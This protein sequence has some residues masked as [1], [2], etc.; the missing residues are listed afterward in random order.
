[1]SDTDDAGRISAQAAGLERFFR[2]ATLT[3]VNRV[4]VALIVV[5]GL[6]VALATAS[7]SRTHRGDAVEAAV[8]LS[9]G[10]ALLWIFLLVMRYLGI[11]RRLHD[12][13]A[14]EVARLSARP[15]R[16]Q[17]QFLAD[18]ELAGPRGRV[19]SMSEDPVATRG[20]PYGETR[21]LEGL[22]P[23]ASPDGVNRTRDP[24]RGPIE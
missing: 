4:I 3:M 2:R 19:G 24:Q 22:G 12:Q 21:N 18:A 5:G 11:R 17:R 14:A 23:D 9:L 1:M 6:A 16:H 8:F 7:S 10:V 20:D 13:P 15:G